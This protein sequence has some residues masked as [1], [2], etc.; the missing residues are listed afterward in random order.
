[1]DE[2]KEYLKEMEITDFE[3][4]LILASK[5]SHELQAYFFYCIYNFAK[6]RENKRLKKLLHKSNIALYV[7]I[8]M[9]LINLVIKFI[10]G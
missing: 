6:K 9:D 2:F 1:M 8:A 4:E 3:N 10:R 7:I 5:S